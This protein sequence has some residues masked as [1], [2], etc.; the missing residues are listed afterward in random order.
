[1]ESPQPQNFA[2]NIEPDN[3]T[4]QRQEIILPQNANQYNND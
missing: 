4:L 1:M 2:H 3:N